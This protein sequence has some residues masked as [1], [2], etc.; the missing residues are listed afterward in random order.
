MV[1]KPSAA[2]GSAVWA[3]PHQFR[4][5]AVAVYGARAARRPRIVGRRAQRRGAALVPPAT[6][7]GGGRSSECASRLRALTQGRPQGVAVPSHRS[8]P[9]SRNS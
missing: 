2:G 4:P 3:R 1:D 7:V 8:A 5:L 6:R 9:H